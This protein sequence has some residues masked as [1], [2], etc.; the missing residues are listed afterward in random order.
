MCASWGN[1]AGN[2]VNYFIFVFI[3]IFYIFLGCLCLGILEKGIRVHR[4]IFRKDN[5][6]NAIKSNEYSDLSKK[7]IKSIKE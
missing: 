4:R 1:C 5:T 3:F 7:K 6:I 2:L